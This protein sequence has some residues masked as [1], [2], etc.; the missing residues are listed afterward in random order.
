MNTMKYRLYVMITTL[1]M[2]LAVTTAVAAAPAQTAAGEKK[3][4][5]VFSIEKF[6]IG[7]GYLVLP[8]QVEMETDASVADVFLKVAQ[9]RGITYKSDETAYTFFLRSI[10]HADTGI[11]NIP[12]EISQMPPY[13]FS[14]GSGE[15]DQIV[16]N[17][18]SNEKN[19]GNHLEEG[20]LGESSYHTMAGWMFTVN[21]ESISESADSVP[22]KDGDVIRLQ[23]SVYGY[24]ADL[25]FDTEEWTGIP[26]IVLADRD[27]LMREVAATNSDMQK[28]TEIKKAYED[29]L[30]VLTIYQASQQEIDNALEALK[31]AKKT[32][33]AM[34]ETT[35]KPQET[36]PP[37]TENPTYPSVKRAQ[38]KK[39]KNIKKYKAKISV[40]KITGV[41]GYQYKYAN[42]KKFKNATVKITTKRTLITKK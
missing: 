6:T 25:G 3:A 7:Q 12:K 41:K 5:V 34:S 19:E 23:F 13:Q 32:Y 21:N 8:I 11:I 22:V 28:N 20:A 10:Y 40:K 31:N 42:N 38:I 39:I 29:A 4:T 27:A 9:E 35:K 14:F 33:Q 37:T 17:A 16:Y 36:Q 30:S 26:R 15:E 2:T 18:P 1:F 24:G